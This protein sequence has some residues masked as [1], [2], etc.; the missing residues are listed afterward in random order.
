MSAKVPLEDLRE[1]VSIEF[2]NWIWDP[3]VLGTDEE[4]MFSEVIPAR[5]CVASDFP[6]DSEFDVVLEEDKEDN[7]M[8]LCMEDIDDI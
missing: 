8:K 4:K 6:E 2:T 1:Y 3:S 7:M 5:M